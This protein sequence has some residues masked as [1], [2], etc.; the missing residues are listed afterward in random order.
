MV[1]ASLVVSAC[2]PH[3]TFVAWLRNAPDSATPLLDRWRASHQADGYESKLDAVI[4][5]LPRYHQLDPTLPGRLGFEP[6]DATAIIAP[7]ID[8][9]TK[10]H[11][12]MTTGQ[13]AERPMFF[14]NVPSVRDP[15]LQV[16]NDHVLSVETLFTPYRLQG[17]WAAS[18]EPERWLDVYGER[19]QPGFRDHVERYRTMTPETYEREFFMPRGYATSFAGGPLAALRGRRPELT[20]YETPVA[21]AST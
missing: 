5:E 12:L 8:Q 16:G 19:V 6:L 1:E 20:R 11:R 7:T 17:G 15:S 4:T 2:D 10:A 18:S 3:A 14:A 21:R 13:V 9:M